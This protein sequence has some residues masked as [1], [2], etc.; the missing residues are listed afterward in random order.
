VRTIFQASLITCVVFGLLMGHVSAQ[1]TWSDG[2]AA[3]VEFPR[4]TQ[5]GSTLLA[6][7]AYQIQHQVIDGRDYLAVH[8]TSRSYV[9]GHHYFGAVVEEVA[10]VSSRII[11]T[12]AEQ[13]DTAVYIKND[14]DGTAVVTRVVIRGEKAIHIVSTES[15]LVSTRGTSPQ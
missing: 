9:P 11:S 2:N 3:I 4:T 5:I 6:P 14:A 12:P 1:V 13:P 15:R 7:G 10:R 8:V